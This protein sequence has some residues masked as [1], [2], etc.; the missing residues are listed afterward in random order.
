MLPSATD[1]EYF[2]EVAK[3]GNISRAAE[4]LGISQPALT[5]SIQKLEH[6][7]GV[8]LLNRSRSGVHLTRAGQ[9]VL[10]QTRELLETWNSLR[11]SALEEETEIKGQF[12][13]GCHPSAGRYLLPVFFAELAKKAPQIEVQIEHDLSRKVTESVVSYRLDFAFAINPPQ[14]PD[15][16][17]KKLGTD[18]VTIFENRKKRYT[19]VLLGHP[20]LA[21]TQFI[22]AQLK[23]SQPPLKYLPCSNLELIQTLVVSG[24]GYGILPTRVAQH[25][26]AKP[27]DRAEIPVKPHIDEI[28]LVYRK[29]VMASRAGRL[30]LE[31]AK[32]V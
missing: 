29:E 10:N 8:S 16:V 30:V 17:L 14:H 25:G 2:S 7:V 20:D 22:L 23:K 18:E 13:L 3:A 11:K 28:Y 24:Y 4:R 26:L 31:V 27:L 5:Q 1:L 12:R 6:V 15:L 21:Q 19:D 32:R 9:K